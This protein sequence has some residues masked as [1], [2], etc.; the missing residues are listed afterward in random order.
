MSQR[1]P[2]E[3]PD[4]Q[5]G[6][7]AS[8]TRW[9]LSALGLAAMALLS[10]CNDKSPPA[11]PQASAP[12][13]STSSTSPATTAPAPQAVAAAYVPPSADVIYQMVAPIA[14]YPDKLVAQI[15]AGSTYPD[16]ISAAETWLAQNPG[17]QKA[18]MASAVNAQ[19]WDPSVKSLTEFPNV[20]E[21]LA[22][23]MPWTTALGK[24]YYNDPS[25][26]MNAIQ[27]MRNRA[28]K[29][30]ALKTS[31]QLKVNVAAQPSSV[32]YTASGMAMPLAQSVISAPEQYVEIEP[33]QVQTVYVPQYDPSLVYGEPL[34]VY[35][36][37]RYSMAPR[38]AVVS[39]TTPVVAGILGFGAGVLLINAA[40]R[41]PSWGW[42]AWDMHW[43]EPGHQWRPGNPP[44]P[45]QARPAVVYNHQTYI[46]QS[47]T[48]ENNIRRTE[49]VHVTNNIYENAPPSGQQA[50]AAPMQ[51]GMDHG[52]GHTGAM[53]AAAAAGVGGA[54]LAAGA[55]AH[56]HNADARTQAQ[57]QAQNQAAQA[58]MQA[59]ARNQAQNPTQPH[60]Q[61][62]M[63]PNMASAP[64]APVGNAASADARHQGRDHNQPA[65]PAASPAAPVANNHD[66]RAQ[67]NP[68]LS[69][70]QAPAMQQ[71]GQ[72]QRQQAMQ[73][74]QETQQQQQMQRA[75]QEQ[76]RAQ[77]H[78]QQQNQ[79]RQQQQMQQRQQQMQ[80]RQA[81]QQSQQQARMQAQ[82]QHQ[83]AQRA[84]QQQHQAAAPAAHAQ[85]H[86][87]HNRHEH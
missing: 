17:M 70:A 74:R 62:G 16:Q 36:G 10:A 11:E 55:I 30:G 81:E 71:H 49:N 46:S 37:Y 56:G 48:V 75:Q 25:D 40:D 43:G 29:A 44:P 5:S 26:V 13:S 35:Q 82:A 54:A 2:Q 32:E 20:L 38:P 69:Q 27:V 50:G 73:A 63:H 23:N 64:M 59:Q 6:F 15:L 57:A 39:V 9:R 31:K 72:E 21:Q 34:P 7:K 66:T 22:S 12:A 83:Q 79:Q 53:A 45:P 18:A 51:Q 76:Q 19:S 4:H 33:S 61:P 41:H 84:Q 52:G 78:A 24:V 14:L 60:S 47:R 28:Y 65:M 86:D 87:N 8:P 42:H 67:G 68:H 85:P 58:Q 3:Q 80:Q 77:M 1:Q